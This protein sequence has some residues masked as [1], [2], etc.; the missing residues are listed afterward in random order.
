[1]AS[2]TARAV[3]APENAAAG[4]TLLVA[5]LVVTVW[6]ATPTATKLALETLEPVPVAAMRTGLAG[7]IALPIALALRLRLPRDASDW[8]QLFV[9]GLS[10]FVVFPMLLAIGLERTSASHAALI[11]AVGPIVTGMIACAL[12]RCW[13]AGRWWAGVTIA[14]VGEYL[15][16]V[17]RDGAS[18]ARGNLTGDLVCVAAMAFVSVSYVTGSHLSRRIGAWSTTFWGVVLA[19][20]PALTWMGFSVGAAGMPDPSPISLASVVFLAVATTILGYAGWFWALANG[21]IGRVAPLQFL[22]PIIG[23][24]LAVALLSD[25]LTWR[26]VVAGAAVISGVLIAS[27]SRGARQ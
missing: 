14:I 24:I 16:I 21:G 1:M 10:A 15:L 27:W 18:L 12:D 9:S 13:P 3:A 25:P 22:V 7:L 23:V 4:A 8:G 19:A 5:G 17:G 20:V 6:G 2:T 26:L 11:I